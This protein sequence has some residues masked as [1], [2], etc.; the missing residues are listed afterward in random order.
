LEIVQA[1]LKEPF[2]EA[3]FSTEIKTL[4]MKSGILLIVLARKEAH[5]GMGTSLETR[6]AAP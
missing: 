4:E 6:Q 1:R 2:V 5:E 3:G